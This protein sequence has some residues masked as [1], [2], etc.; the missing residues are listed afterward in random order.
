MILRRI[1][2]AIRRQDWFTVFIEICIV[3]IGL[4]IGLK[5]N[6]WNEARAE[7]VQEFAFMER[8]SEDVDRTREQLLAFIEQRESR[9]NTIALVENMYF[10]DGEIEPLSEWECRQFASMHLITL[11]PIAVPSITEA[12]VSGSIDLL[13]KTSLIQA[14][15]V[16]KQSEDR[17]RTVIDSMRKDFPVLSQKYP[18][19]ISWRRATDLRKDLHQIFETEG[20]EMAADCHFIET[21][22]ERDFLSDVVLGLQRNQWYV[23]F[24]NRHLVK[25]NDLAMALKGSSIPSETEK[26]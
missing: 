17:L 14:L 8:L 1:S 23:N 20:Y 11:P 15:I 26:S 7:R 6:N 19:A 5:I 24:L 4:L 13:S 22:A 9:L 21:T 12:F 10:G 16:V 3:V 18:N 2:E 25:L